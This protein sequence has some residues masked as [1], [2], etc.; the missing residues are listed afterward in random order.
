[1]A[2]LRTLKPG[3]FTDDRLAEIHPLGRLLFQGLWCIADRAGRLED[4]PR[5]IKAEVLPYD[6]ADVDGLLTE[7]CNAGFIQRYAVG[8]ARLIQVLSFAKHQNPHVREPESTIPAPDEHS[9]SPV[10]DTEP[11]PAQP[12]SPGNGL[13]NGLGVPPTPQREEVEVVFEAYKVATERNGTYVLTQKRRKLIRERLRDYPLD[14]VLDACRGWRHF[15]HNRGEN[16]RGTV[17]NDLE[18]L[19]RDAAHVERFRDAERGALAP[20]QAGADEYEQF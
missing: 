10:P 16:E 12:C 4:R 13:V 20:A 5:R 11:A 19:L 7:L 14:D 17:Y 6:D 2:R 9:T 3:F 18:L 15:P 8:E 1:M